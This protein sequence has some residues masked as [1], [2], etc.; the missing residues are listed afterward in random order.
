MSKQLEGKDCTDYRRP[1]AASRAA[2][3]A[4]GRD[5]ANVAITYTKGADA[6]RRSSGDRT[7]GRKHRSSGGATDAG[8]GRSR[9]RK[10]RAASADLMCL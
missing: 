8:A 7:R 9:G 1:R 4:S 10:D 2:I 6:A 5:G 3:P